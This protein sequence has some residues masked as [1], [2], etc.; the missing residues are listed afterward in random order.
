MSICHLKTI[1]KPSFYDTL[2]KKKKNVQSLPRNLWSEKSEIKNHIML[3]Y[4]CELL[5]SLVQI[6]EPKSNSE[7]GSYSR[8]LSILR[9]QI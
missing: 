8:C 5:S 3:F 4:V 2:K 1:P 9:K 7:K 6:L